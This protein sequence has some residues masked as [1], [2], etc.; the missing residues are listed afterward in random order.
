MDDQPETVFKFTAEGIDL[1]FAG[2]ETFV[3]K[4]VERFR[5]FL[6]SAVRQASGLPA[7]PDTEATDTGDAEPESLEAFYAARPTREGR[8]AIQDRILLFLYYLERVQGKQAASKEDIAWCFQQAGLSVP[9]NLLNALGNMKRKLGYLQAGGRR[10]L[11]QL[12]PKGEQ[13]VEARFQR[14]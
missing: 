3:E 11:Y 2:T 8:G 12:A 10:G 13:Y 14:A 6:E 7:K 9:K 5:S 4:Q 1:E